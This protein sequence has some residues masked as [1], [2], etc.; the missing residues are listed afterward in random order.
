MNTPKPT[1]LAQT[2]L[3]I[4]VTLATVISVLFLM[5]VSSI[6]PEASAEAKVTPAQDA[7][8]KV[9]VS[10]VDSTRI[11]YDQGF[12]GGTTKGI[13]HPDPLIDDKDVATG[14]K[15]KLIR[16]SVPNMP[17]GTEVEKKCGPAEMCAVEINTNGG[18]KIRIADSASNVLQL[19]YP[20]RNKYRYACPGG[21]CAAYSKKVHVTNIKLDAQTYNC[22]GNKCNVEIT[23]SVR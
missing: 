17:R 15:I 13:F 6:H 10:G 12:P 16:V 18:G 7:E 4:I 21:N 20:S 23:Y 11:D 2:R 14:S 5:T 1:R 22:P 19:E 3:G 8:K 9:T